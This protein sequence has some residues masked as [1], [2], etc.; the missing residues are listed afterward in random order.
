MCERYSRFDLWNLGD[1]RG[2]AVRVLFFEALSNTDAATNQ[3]CDE[4]QEPW[5]TRFLL[6][7]RLRIISK[8]RWVVFDR[9][10]VG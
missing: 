3:A 4:G 10:R 2:R 5:E 9:L 7:F 8:H 6:W 1:A